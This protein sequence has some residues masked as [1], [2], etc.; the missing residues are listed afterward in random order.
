MNWDLGKYDSFKRK[1][2]ILNI[3]SEKG[4]TWSE[5]H[6][7]SCAEEFCNMLGERIDFE[8]A[9]QRNH[10][11]VKITITKRTT[12]NHKTKTKRDSFMISF[13]TKMFNLRFVVY[14][15]NCTCK[16]FTRSMRMFLKIVNLMY[17]IYFCSLQTCCQITTT[18][19][20]IRQ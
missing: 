11:H 19:M 6:K 18:K 15:R 4:C 16:S 17:P 8:A 3:A 5:R 20:I 14:S 2:C 1:L 12:T 10:W 9:R 7:W 13:F